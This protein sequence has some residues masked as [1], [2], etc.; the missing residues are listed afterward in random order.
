MYLWGKE[1]NNNTQIEKYITGIARQLY[2]LK[3]KIINTIASL[4]LQVRAL[5]K[6]LQMGERA[7][8]YAEDELKA[9]SQTYAQLKVCY[10]SLELSKHFFGPLKTSYLTLLMH[11]GTFC[12]PVPLK[13]HRVEG[14]GHH[15]RNMKII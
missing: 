12:T 8:K 5:H 10:I 1:L 7:K 11:I 9:M 13:G 3:A 4:C 6:Q 15:Y 2:S 14:Q